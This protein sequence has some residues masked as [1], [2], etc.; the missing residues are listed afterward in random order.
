M[1]EDIFTTEIISIRVVF[2]VK[3]NF[4]YTVKNKLRQSLKNE[5]LWI[6]SVFE[7]FPMVLNANIL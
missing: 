5:C 4:I 7:Y 2:F 6:G 3:L 1:A